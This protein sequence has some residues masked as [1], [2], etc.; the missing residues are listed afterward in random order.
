MGVH[1]TIENPYNLKLASYENEE[2]RSEQ[3]PTEAGG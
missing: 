2:Y 1:V 3:G